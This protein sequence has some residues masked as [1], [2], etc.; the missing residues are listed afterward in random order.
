MKKRGGP[1][2]VSFSSGGLSDLLSSH[3]FGACCGVPSPSQNSCCNLSLT[4]IGFGPFS[5]FFSE[6]QRFLTMS[7]DLA[8][9]GIP[10]VQ[11]TQTSEPE[12]VGVVWQYFKSHPLEATLNHASA[13]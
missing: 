4:H 11:R 6:Q 9:S 1:Q 5:P 2:P 3:E 7:V 12:D 10:R 8:A 13:A